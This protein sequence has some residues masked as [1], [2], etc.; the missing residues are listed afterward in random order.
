MCAFE[1]MLRSVRSSRVTH[2][3][4]RASLKHER[5]Q[6]TNNENTSNRLLNEPSKTTQLLQASMKP[7]KG[8]PVDDSPVKEALVAGR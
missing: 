2:T 3:I 7:K 5:F 1:D 6:W 8:P 4:S